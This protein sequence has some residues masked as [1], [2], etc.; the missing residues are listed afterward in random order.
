MVSVPCWPARVGAVQS[1]QVSLSR[2]QV[3]S[4]EIPVDL[5]QSQ[6]HIFAGWNWT[7]SPGG[8]SGPGTWDWIPQFWFQVV[9][10]KLQNAKAAGRLGPLSL[11]LSSPIHEEGMCKRGSFTVHGG[12][13]SPA[14][15]LPALALQVCLWAGERS[16]SLALSTFRK[17]P[18]P[19]PCQE[20]EGGGNG[21]SGLG[22]WD[23]EEFRH[24][25]WLEA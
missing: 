7:G 24:Q 10:R 25:R 6:G 12:W 14:P 5:W 21:P 18:A 17:H 1:C 16:F 13:G 20:T 11:D 22:V 3:L 8:K 4:S 2:F 9:F 23:L 19:H 15:S